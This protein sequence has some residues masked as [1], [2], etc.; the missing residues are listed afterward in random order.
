MKRFFLALLAAILLV[1]V[2]V[3][4]KTYTFKSTQLTFPSSQAA[5]PSE[6]TIQHLS[7][8]IKF[9]T[10][11]YGD[12]SKLDTAAFFGL[13]RFLQKTYPLTF[14]KLTLTRVAKYSLLFRWAGSR[15]DLNPIIFMAHQDVVPV[16]EAAASLWTVDPYAGTVKDGSIWGRGT[17]D[18]KIN[19][20][21]M[22]EAVEALLA[23]GYTPSRTLY[24]CFGH[25]EEMGGYGAQT[26][27]KLLL[28]EGIHPDLILDEGGIV[29]REK[30]PGMKVPVALIGTSEK[31]YMT[32][33]LSVEKS[34]GHS[35]MPETET[36]IDILTKAIVRLRE[37]PFESRFSPST[38]GF[39][40][41]LGPEMPFT[42]RMA[43]ANPWLF[44]P[45]IKGIYEQSAGGNAMI[46]TTLVPTILD[47]GIKDNVI[48]TRA[49]ASVNVRLLPGDSSSFVLSRI[50]EIINDDRVKIARQSQF[51]HEPSAVT[52]E[53]SYAYQVVNEAAK[54][55]FDNVITS[56]FLM[57]GAT[58]SRHFAKVSSGI[59]KF[60]P[61]IDPV[62]FHGIDERVSLEGYGRA[63][64]FYDQLI[65]I[66]NR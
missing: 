48:P 52:D 47:A 34:G 65:A 57:I 62:G 51:V 30:V 27:A 54:R 10:I 4:F 63:L 41:N 53:T 36:S 16:E 44:T 29:T 25:D 66:I 58:D 8:A 31:G 33:S 5:T 55:S 1:I 6:G 9:K 23:K 38:E 35:S 59:I 15:A 22:L 50:T 43:F 42:N 28:D 17:A 11:S 7:D 21:A 24:L 19:L 56:P 14:S 32:V 13:H 18:D 2:I 49:E 60:S 46:R 3:L 12:T 39:M 20:I 26:M 61:M 45:M 37:H 64:L 40:R